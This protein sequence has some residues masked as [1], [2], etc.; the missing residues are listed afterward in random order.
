MR[1]ELARKAVKVCFQIELLVFHETV[2]PFLVA[3]RQCVARHFISNVGKMAIL[4][5]YDAAN[6]SSCEIED[7]AT[8][9]G[10]LG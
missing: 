4:I 8:I 5:S 6:E 3:C 2:K 9:T 7:P 10:L 1:G